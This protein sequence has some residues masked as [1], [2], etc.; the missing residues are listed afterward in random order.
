MLRTCDEVSAKRAQKKYDAIYLFSFSFST[1]KHYY[2]IIVPVC[3]TV[4]FENYR[5]RSFDSVIFA[6]FSHSLNKNILSVR[7]SRFFFKKKVYKGGLVCLEYWSP[8]MFA[9]LFCT[10]FFVEKFRCDFSCGCGWSLCYR[11]ITVDDELQ[12][13]GLGVLLG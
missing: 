8:F 11:A 6:H 7:F 9:V 10:R 1:Y 12:F 13:Y 5:V 2:F 3:H 4:I